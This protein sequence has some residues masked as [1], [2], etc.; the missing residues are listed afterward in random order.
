MISGHASV[1]V[2]I[3]DAAAKAV[4]PSIIA[5]RNSRQSWEIRAAI[6]VSLFIFTNAV[7]DSKA[8]QPEADHTD[9]IDYIHVLECKLT[10]PGSRL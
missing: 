1:K 8:C 10:D 5:N 9:Q 4:S 3:K 7:T 2:N 6:S